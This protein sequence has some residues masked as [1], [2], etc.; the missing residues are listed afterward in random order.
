MDMR[1]AVRDN[2]RVDKR[3]CNPV[4][5]EEKGSNAATNDSFVGVH[6]FKWYTS[7]PEM[8]EAH[9]SAPAL[10]AEDCRINGYNDCREI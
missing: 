4:K 7:K 10:R 1:L 5:F 6:E 2:L 9:R 8:Q 3:V